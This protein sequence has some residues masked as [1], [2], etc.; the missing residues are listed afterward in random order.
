MANKSFSST[1][2]VQALNVYSVMSNTASDPRLHPEFLPPREHAVH[3]VEDFR[4]KL[5]RKYHSVVHGWRRLFGHINEVPQETFDEVMRSVMESDRDFYYEYRLPL[6]GTMG[7]AG[8]PGGGV[9][10]VGTAGDDEDA[11][12]GDPD[13]DP[14]PGVGRNVRRPDGFVADPHDPN[15]MTGLSLQA[16]G[17]PN[18][19]NRG[20][21]LLNEKEMDFY[22]RE[23]WRGFFVAKCIVRLSEDPDNSD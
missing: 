17:N 16:A 22:L 3:L 5:L 2:S 4:G 15:Y 21:R 20:L 7:G 18:E 13:Y 11:G 9:Q 23:L 14:M 10:R 12:Y 19:S 6:P 1:R 8:G